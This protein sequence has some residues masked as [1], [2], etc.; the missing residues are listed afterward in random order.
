[1]RGTGARRACVRADAASPR[2]CPPRLGLLRPAPWPGAAP[3]PWGAQL[4]GAGQWVSN[5]ERAGW[6][7][8]PL[9]L[10]QLHPVPA[11]GGG[12]A[13]AGKQRPSLRRSQLGALQPPPRSPRCPW[14]PVTRQTPAAPAVRTRLPGDSDMYYRSPRG[15][16]RAGGRFLENGH[17]GSHLDNV[18]FPHPSEITLE[19]AVLLG[20]YCFPKLS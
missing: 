13:S 1:M 4:L 12:G 10:C 5:L 18:P 6:P 11:S 14:G 16:A 3:A 9:H 7:A 17:V 15:R 19:Q 2:G 20:L 8:G